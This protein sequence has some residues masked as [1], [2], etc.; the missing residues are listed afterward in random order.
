MRVHNIKQGR[1]IKIGPYT[2]SKIELFDLFKS[3]IVITII[4]Y[5]LGIGSRDGFLYNILVSSIAVGTAFLFHELGHK[6]MAQHYGCFAEY[7][8]NNSMLWMALFMSFLGFV[9]LAPGAVIISG[10]VGK[11]RNGMIS[12]AG[13]GVNFIMALIFMMIIVIT[14]NQLIMSISMSGVLIN[15]WIGLFNMIPFGNFDGKKILNWNK[16]IYIIMVVIGLFVTFFSNTIL[17]II[18]SSL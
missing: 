11:R 10:P 8:A 16:I 15:G 18:K 1:P 4:I 6:I 13:P 3:W 12:A 14:K 2:T 9:F 17:S 7:R 5:I